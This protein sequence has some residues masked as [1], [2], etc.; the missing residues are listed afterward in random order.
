MNSFWQLIAGLGVFLLGMSFIEK[1][2][3]RLGGVKLKTFLHEH[4]QNPLKAAI[5]GTFATAILQSSSVI[6]LIVLAFVGAR[7]IQM[8]NA[9]GIIIGAN[10]GTTFTGWQTTQGN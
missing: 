9:L 3:T 10:L 4:T 8:K 6:S 1:S 5:G 7:M 2:L